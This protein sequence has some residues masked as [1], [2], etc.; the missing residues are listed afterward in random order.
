MGYGIYKEPNMMCVNWTYFRRDNSSEKYIPSPFPTSK[1]T[2]V[3]TMNV[4]VDLIAENNHDVL[5]FYI[6]ALGKI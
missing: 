2:L 6:I 3:S 1:I 5:I 4:L